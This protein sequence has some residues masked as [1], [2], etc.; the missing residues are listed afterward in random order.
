[1]TQQH[2]EVVLGSESMEREVHSDHMTLSM[3]Q[4]IIASEEYLSKT[5][6][7]AISTRVLRDRNLAPRVPFFFS[8][9]CIGLTD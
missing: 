8:A 2:Q 6:V 7:I 3:D 4:D 1:M 5:Y 9:S